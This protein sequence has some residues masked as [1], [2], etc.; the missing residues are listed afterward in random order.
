LLADQRDWS[1]NIGQLVGKGLIATQLFVE[2]NGTN[3]LRDG[4]PQQLQNA[5]IP[6]GIRNVFAVPAVQDQ[7]D[8][9]LRQIDG[10]H[11]RADGIDVNRAQG[12]ELGIIQKESIPVFAHD[13]AIQVDVVSQYRTVAAQEFRDRRVGGE[14]VGEKRQGFLGNIDPFGNLHLA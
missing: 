4:R 8:I 12:C 2:K 7:A 10:N 3:G 5:D 1:R 14:H 9:G 13:A 11:A 6:R